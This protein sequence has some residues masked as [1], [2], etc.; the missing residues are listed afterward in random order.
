MEA[1]NWAVMTTAFLMVLGIAESGVVLSAVV[2][3]S[4]AQGG[5]WRDD[6]A[7]Y[8]DSTA[9]LFP[10]GFVLLLILLVSPAATFPHY[11]A[12]GH[13]SSWLNYP[14][15]A[16]REI[17]LYLLIAIV[18]LGY[19]RAGVQH[20]RG[21]TAQTRH[22]LTGFAAAVITLYV[23]YGTVVSWDF[24]MTLTPHFHSAIYAPYFFVSSFGM[25]LGFFVIVMY[26]LRVVSGGARS[27]TDKSFN[28]LAQMMLG[29][30]LLWT[31]TFFS[32]FLTIWYAALPDETKRLF[33]MMFENADI[34][35]GPAEISGLF[36][37]FVMLKSF[38][39]FGLLIF[40]VFRHVPALTALVGVLIVVG[41]FIERFTWVAATYPAWH[42]PLT[43]F[44][45]IA[46]VAIVIAVIVVVL[47]AAY[48]GKPSFLVAPIGSR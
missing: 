11:T 1:V 21:N 27:I 18:S 4:N 42:T 19:L 22:R 10:L 41:T 2:H 45:D 32:Q 30:T 7:H 37:W 28:Y 33:G 23:I 40:S 15:L 46:V 6:I 43:A 35:L 20:D 25:F 48:T 24:G 38:I 31:Y 9:Y 26:I 12:T 39:P 8:A 29:F 36:W 47:R 16:T 34:R 5:T 14:F 3:L 13:I 17:V 44:F